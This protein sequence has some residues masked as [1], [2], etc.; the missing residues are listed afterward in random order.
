MLLK[1][2]FLVL[3]LRKRSLRLEALS[4]I[5]LLLKYRLNNVH[6]IIQL[7]REILFRLGIRVNRGRLQ[8]WHTVSLPWKF[9]E[10]FDAVWGNILISLMLH[11]VPRRLK[12]SPCKVLLRVL[13]TIN[14]SNL[15][16]IISTSFFQIVVLHRLVM[17]M[18]DARR[19]QS[20]SF[21][22]I[23]LSLALRCGHRSYGGLDIGWIFLHLAGR[24]VLLLL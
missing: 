19:N 8:V 23:D 5:A 18:V 21:A 4:L 16:V 6:H 2:I 11:L 7:L 1:T 15:R 17:D 14:P 10:S 20:F 9:W 12:I 22:K 3:G 13:S 24:R